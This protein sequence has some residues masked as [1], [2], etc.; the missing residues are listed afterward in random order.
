M[1]KVLAHLSDVSSL[2]SYL[3]EE[4]M[5]D[6]EDA[7]EQ[8][9][10]SAYGSGVWGESAWNSSDAE[11]GG[12][13]KDVYSSSDE[14]EEEEDHDHVDTD[15]RA[16]TSDFEWEPPGSTDSCSGTDDTDSQWSEWTE[17]EDC[18]GLSTAEG[19][20]PPPLECETVRAR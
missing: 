6:Q 10:D 9:R 13:D 14:E 1:F 17:E 8:E 16:D 2:A 3:E 7:W 19:G 11:S 18:A 20:E 12:S 5:K 15:S 4:M